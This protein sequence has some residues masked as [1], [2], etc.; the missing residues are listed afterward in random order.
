MSGY[1]KV[2]LKKGKERALLNKHPWLFSGAIAHSTKPSI[3]DVVLLKDYQD[4]A[5]ALGHWCDHQGLVCRIISFDVNEA[6]DEHFFHKIIDQAIKLRKRFDLPNEYSN[7]YRLIHGEGDGLSGLVCD[8]YHDTA[9]IILSNPGL[10]KAIDILVHILSTSLGIKHIHCK[11][12]FANHSEWLLG[13]RDHV[14]FSENKLTFK[15]SISSGQKTGHFLDQRDNRLFLQSL[16][17]NSNVLD[18][19][20]YSGGFSVYALSG[21]ANHVLSVDIAKDALCLAQENVLL[22]GFTDRHEYVVDDCFLFLRQMKPDFFD[23]IVLDPPA[24]AKEAKAIDKAARGYKDINRLAMRNIKKGGIILSFSCSQH[25]CEDLWQKIIFA[26]AKDANRQVNIIKKLSQGLDH[27]V[28]IYCPQSFY[29][30]G[31]ALY[32]H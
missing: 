21:G 31:L 27:L 8:I 19:F 22:N 16:A 28:S 30:K 24:F 20:A 17:K 26:A 10:T 14:I 13:Y 25:I 2:Y 12:V 15:A 9:A 23:I 3:S 32:V 29:L 4:N 1:H 6:I 18:A 7:A 11:R 5:L